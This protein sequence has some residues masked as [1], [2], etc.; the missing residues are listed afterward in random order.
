M[1]PNTKHIQ[2]F[3]APYFLLLTVMIAVLIQYPKDEL[4]LLMNKNHTPVGDCFFSIWT[5]F[6]G[7][8][9]PFIII[10]SILLY[11]YSYAVYLLAAQA[12]GQLISIFGKYI[13]DKPRPLSYFQEFFPSITLPTV[14]NIKMHLHYSFPSGHTIT[15]FALFFG[16]AL[17]VKNKW[18]KLL[19]FCMAAT[20]GYSRVYLSQHFAIDTVAGSF[21]GIFS[22]WIFYPLLK[23]MDVKWG[24]SSLINSFCKK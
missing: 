10:F 9:V 11:R 21:V 14:E 18:L 16:L 3:L 4:H 24:K 8:F 6:G 12:I 13:F 7:S 2:Y 1:R 23:K 15:A 22:A 5:E 17:L 20:V 19:F